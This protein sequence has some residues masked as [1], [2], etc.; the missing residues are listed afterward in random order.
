P[1]TTAPAPPARKPAKTPSDPAPTA[2]AAPAG[3]SGQIA[4]LVNAERA[5]SG[6]G[7]VRVNGKLDAAAAKHSADMDRRDF[8]DH[9]NP[10]GE[11]PGDRITASGYRWSTYG[12]NIARGQR[13]AAQV[14]RTW[15]D[16]PGHRANILNCD[17]KEIGVGRHDAAG[18]P[19]WTQV[20]GT[21]R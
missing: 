15:M 11:N 7:P 16:S 3:T 14:M 21:A 6:C 13:S 5:K 2:P 10:D 18:G 17:F 9:E 1:R 4:A 8:F 12:E 19:W 20:F